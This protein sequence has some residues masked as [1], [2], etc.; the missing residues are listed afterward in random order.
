M[1]LKK[2]SLI[3]PL[4]IVIRPTIRF[5]NFQQRVYF[6]KVYL[7]D[8]KINRVKN[9]T[10]NTYQK[11]RILRKQNGVVLNFMIVEV[12]YEFSLDII[13]ILKEAKTIV[14][15]ILDLAVSRKIM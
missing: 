5:F 7:I 3:S 6:S 8:S 2:S 4:I 11:K 15:F 13:N 9:D 12:L 14:I 1:Y 10:T